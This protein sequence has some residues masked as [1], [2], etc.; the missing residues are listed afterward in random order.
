M[1]IWIDK[2]VVYIVMG[3]TAAAL[4]AAVS[5]L[6]WFSVIP[7]FGW[8]YVQ[9]E[10]VFYRRFRAFYDDLEG[11]APLRQLR[12]RADSITAETA[13]ILRGAGLVQA[14]VTLVAL[15]RRAVPDAAG[16]A[17]A[18]GG[19]AVPAGGRRRRAPGHHAAAR[20]WCSTTSICAA[21]R[22]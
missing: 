18:G 7:A 2:V 20:S 5:A 3:H 10:T 8:I 14:A 6:A 17:V 12:A 15:V 19:A 1:S 22:S 16:R 13:R 11:G 4:Y 9:I 21:T